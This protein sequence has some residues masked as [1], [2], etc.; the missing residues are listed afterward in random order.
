MT[1]EDQEES[2]LEG[3]EVVLE[4]EA[5]QEQLEYHHKLV[6]NGLQKQNLV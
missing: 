3:G 2:S 6:S 5:K 1:A 4:A